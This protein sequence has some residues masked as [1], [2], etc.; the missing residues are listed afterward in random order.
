[1]RESRAGITNLLVIVLLG[2]SG[3][4]IG[5]DS[6]ELALLSRT[7]WSAFECSALASKIGNTEQQQKLFLYGYET[8]IS[9]IEALRDGRI[10]REDISRETPLIMMM[11]L[12]GPSPDFMLGRVFEAAMEA[13]F[14]GVYETNGNSNDDEVQAM[15]AESKYQEQNCNLLGN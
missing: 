12:Q 3:L 4:L 1:M 9:F 14:E 15:L 10:E 5:Q 8:G 6:S 7:S 11:L 2:Y 13:A